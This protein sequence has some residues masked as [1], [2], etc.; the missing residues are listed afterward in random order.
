MILNH[1]PESVN[2]NFLG[3]REPHIYGSTT[4][5]EIEASCQ[6]LADSSVS[7]SAFHQSNHGGRA[8]Q[9]DPVGAWQG[10]RHHHQPGRLFLHLD[11]ADRCAQDIRRPEDRGAH[12][13]YPRQGRISPPLDHVECIH[14]GHLRPRPV[15]LHRRDPG[16]RATTGT[17]AE[18]D[19]GTPC[20]ALA[21]GGKA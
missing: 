20:T 19:S 15:R 12:L 21:A 4:L 2:L 1:G 9:S 13:Q 11:R 17:I 14:G 5:E 3:I 7:R 8:R 10:G 16:G 18:I 6:A